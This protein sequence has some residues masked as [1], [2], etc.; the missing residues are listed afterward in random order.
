MAGAAFILRDVAE[1]DE[2]E[3]EGRTNAGAKAPFRA[4]QEMVILCTLARLSI[5]WVVL[6]SHE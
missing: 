1:S 5:S 2:K 3:N 4:R 6:I